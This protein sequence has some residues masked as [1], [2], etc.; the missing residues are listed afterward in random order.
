MKKTITGLIL[1]HLGYISTFTGI[2][3]NRSIEQQFYA[4]LRQEKN[5]GNIFIFIGIAA[6]V[7][8]TLLL[9]SNIKKAHK[10]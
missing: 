9:L 3:R 1:I 10:S 2:L 6:I 4:A 5:P 7:V 8:G